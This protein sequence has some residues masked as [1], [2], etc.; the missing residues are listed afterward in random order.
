MPRARSARK[1]VEELLTISRD[2]ARRTAPFRPGAPV[3]AVYRPL[4]YAWRPHEAYLRKFGGSG[5]HALLVG[6]N[7][8]PFGMAQ[9]GVP[10]GEVELVRSW[11]GIEEPVDRP[12]DEHPKRPVRGFDCHRK[13]VSGSR[14]WGWARD[15]F[16]T[17][18]A[19]FASFFVWN[20]CPLCF[21][22]ESGA[23]LTPDQLSPDERAE[24][25]AI[26]DEA[27]GAVARLFR[28]THVIGIGG[29]AEA[30][31]RAVL[32]DGDAKV[33]RV[34]HPSPASPIANRGWAERAEREL[35]ALGAL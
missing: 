2:L 33:G 25:F 5:A 32:G 1:H 17:P 9:T 31:I 14:L 7:P 21:V 28:P 10:F 4:E 18:E 26:C 30:R 27:L 16:G 13:E 6:M 3:A 20:Y 11:M 15:R 12:A 19:F 35:Q 34:L 24:L 8:G 22:K 29:F 23:N